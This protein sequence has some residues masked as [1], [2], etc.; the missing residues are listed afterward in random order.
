M[1]FLWSTSIQNI[2]S[3]GDG[4]Q[5]I[6]PP[7]ELDLVNTAAMAVKDVELLDEMTDLLLA[8]EGLTAK[9]I[10]SSL[11]VD[12][13]R[14]NR[15]L[16]AYT[17]RFMQ[18]EDTPPLWY[19]PENWEQFEDE[20]PVEVVGNAS[21]VEFNLYEWQEKALSLWTSNS[22]R[23]I[24]EA[25]TGA[26]KTRLAIAA[27]HGHLGEG[28]KAVVIVP[29]IELLNQWAREISALIPD[30]QLG[31][32]GNGEADTLSD[33]DVLIAVVNSA[34]ARDLELPLGETGL[35]IGDECHRYGAEFSQLALDENFEFR[36]GLSATYERGDGAHETVLVP[37]FGEVIYSIG[38]AEA[39]AAGIIANVRVATIGVNFTPQERSDYNQHTDEMSE[40]RKHLVA[41]FG[42]HASTPAEFFHKV[43][44]LAES[45][46]RMAKRAAINYLSPYQKRRKLLSESKAKLDCLDLLHG[47]IR[48]AHATLVFTQ[49][50][51]SCDEIVDRL[52]AAQIPAAVVHSKLKKAER[53]A[54]FGAFASGHL[55]ALTAPLVLDEGVDVPEADLALIVAGTS[56]RRQMIQRMGRIMRK[57]KDQRDA[58]FVILYIKETLE[59]PAE[60][61]HEGFFSEIL[62]IAGQV[63][64]FNDSSRAD[65]ITSFLRP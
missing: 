19:V 48:D 60:G 52:I 40:A 54:C 26:G 45:D 55:K 61:S 6:F 15:L 57:K 29:T 25:V 47:A 38:F 13:K 12:K 14:I 3:R 39:I 1:D 34:R 41:K 44:K 20:P 28:R 10:A 32:M 31:L 33:C 63:K 5:S 65:D 37:Y 49:T 59:D 30:V 64:R 18:S 35:L 58:R 24:V 23:G 8:D 43:S 50:I 36:M 21:P 11:D 27:I 56:Q 7:P 46:D 4:I 17:A 53:Q 62:D 2:T 42:L 16:Y 51:A 22:G 9:E